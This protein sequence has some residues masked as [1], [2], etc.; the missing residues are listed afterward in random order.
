[1]NRKKI[2]VLAACAV[3][4]GLALTGC[5]A[6]NKASEPWNDASR[7]GTQYRF[8]WNVIPAPDGFKNSATACLI[9]P[10]GTHTHIRMFRGF[11][12]TNKTSAF[13]DDVVDPIGCP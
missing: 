1:M 8:T 6:N 4:G 3:T 2:A 13:G 5:T 10:D 12:Q 11:N 7:S 9:L